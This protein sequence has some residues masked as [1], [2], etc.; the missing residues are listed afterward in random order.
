VLGFKPI[1]LVISII[2]IIIIIIVCVCV[3]Q[4]V[5]TYSKSIMVHFLNKLAWIKF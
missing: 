2:I 3:C 1:L 4:T 5:E